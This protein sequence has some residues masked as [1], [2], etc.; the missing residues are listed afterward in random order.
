MNDHDT[1]ALRDRLDR[2]ADRFT[3]Q[4]D[5]VELVREARVRNRRQR[6]SRLALLAV[7]TATAVVVP[8]GIAALDGAAPDGRNAAGPGADGEARRSETAEQA[9][10]ERARA[11]DGRLVRELD[12]RGGTVAAAFEARDTPVSL[13]APA[14]RFPCPEDGGSLQAALGVPLKY[15]AG[16]LPGDPG[17]CEWSLPGSSAGPLSEYFATNIGFSPSWTEDDLD[18]GDGLPAEGCQRTVVSHSTTG[19]G[20]YHEAM[21]RAMV[22]DVCVQEPDAVVHWNLGVPDTSGSG[23]WWIGATTG[24]D[25]RVDGAAAVMAVLD[26]ADRTW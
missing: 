8:V 26:L 11:E 12:A 18:H 17:T 15:L 22:L 1:T 4:V 24:T 9:R 25:Q 7:A 23:V 19:P 2:L 10:E 16:T 20:A 6:R 3:P 14:G 21:G 5:V 13:T